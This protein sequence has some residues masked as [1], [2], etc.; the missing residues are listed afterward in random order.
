MAQRMKLPK[1][2]KAYDRRGTWFYYFRRKGFASVRLPG[3]PWSPEFMAAYALALEGQ[4]VGL[5]V[6]AGRC[7]AGSTEAAILS[8]LAST[9]GEKSFAKDPKSAETKRTHRGTLE[10]FSARYGELPFHR[11]DK[12]GVENVL[13][14][15]ADRPGAARNLRNVLRAACAAGPWPR[16]C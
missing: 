9:R 11:L 10:R 1:Y 16:D 6:A 2:V 15:M 14:D 8:Y 7:A 5:P 3:K 13:A 12:R 4:K